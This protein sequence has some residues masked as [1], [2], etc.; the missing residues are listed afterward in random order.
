MGKEKTRTGNFITEMVT[1]DDNLEG[2]WEK[3]VHNRLNIKALKLRDV[4]C[5]NVV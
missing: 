2:C 5:N 1:G 4:Q 3:S